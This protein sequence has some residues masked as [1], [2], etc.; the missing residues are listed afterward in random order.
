MGQLCVSLEIDDSSYHSVCKLD[1][2]PSLFS[3]RKG[4]KSLHLF[5]ADKIEV[6]WDLTSAKFGP[7]SG[8]EPVEGYYIAIVCKHEMVL[9]IGDLRKEAFKKSGASLVNN[10]CNGSVSSSS[11][12]SVL[13]SKRECILGKRA[14]NTKAQFCDGGKIHDLRIEYDAN[15]VVG[16]DND[17]GMSHPRLVVRV[18]SKTVMQVKHLQWKFRGN[19]SVLIDGMQV[20]VFWDVHNWIFGSGVGNAVFM[21]QT[22]SL[23]TEKIAWSNTGPFL[24]SSGVLSLR[25]SSSF[26]DHHHHHHPEFPGFS[27]FLYAWKSE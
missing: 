8:P 18:D 4:S 16:D 19:C 10:G 3:K 9:L 12:S 22:G 21:F 23:L 11:S 17:E 26:R 1:V 13:I 2:K 20:E 27:L 24:D 14:F 5:H 15:V 7:G 25:C 6:F